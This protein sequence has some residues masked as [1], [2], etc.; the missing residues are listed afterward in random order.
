MS[1]K[2]HSIIRVGA[3]LIQFVYGSHSRLATEL[4]LHKIIFWPSFRASFWGVWDLGLC[5]FWVPAFR[6]PLSDGKIW[7]FLR[8]KRVF[9]VSRFCSVV[10]F[11]QVHKKCTDLNL[12]LLYKLILGT[13]SKFAR[14][15]NF[16]SWCAR[17]SHRRAA[18]LRTLRWLNPSPC[19]VVNVVVVGPFEGE[20]EGTGHGSQRRS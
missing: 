12:S 4:I 2:H 11:S 20:E 5:I 18:L 7:C 19:R 10:L 6:D 13:Y 17:R 14:E 9:S 15:N 8:A 1:H 16:Q 3:G